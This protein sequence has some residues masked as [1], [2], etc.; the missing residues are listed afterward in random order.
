MIENNVAII[1]TKRQKLNKKKKE[2][3]KEKKA[4][5]K[6]TDVN[7]STKENTK[8][9]Y[10]NKFPLVLFGL[11]FSNLSTGDIVRIQRI[12]KRFQAVA[13]SSRL[14]KD[15]TAD[16][17]KATDQDMSARNLLVLAAGNLQRLSLFTSK[18]FGDESASH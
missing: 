7:G 12:N 3:K 18:A 6:T 13:K 11:I 5:K 9:N 4:L 2:K 16:L 8:T 15:I 10:F 17:S 1:L 14:F